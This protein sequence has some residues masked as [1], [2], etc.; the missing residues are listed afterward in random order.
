M[1]T[2]KFVEKL[3]EAIALELA[4]LLQYNQYGQVL[5]GQ[6]RRVWKDFFIDASDEALS[7]VR[8]WGERVV[9]LGG[10]PCVEPDVVM[11]TNDLKQMLENSLEVEKRAVVIY[12]EA[13]ALT[14]RTAY[15][16]MLEDHIET[17]TQ[18]VEELLMYLDK[19]KKV[20]PRSKS[21]KAKQTG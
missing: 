6:D 1:D 8:K 17:E 13:L 21:S 4:A 9:A 14:D 12:E 16:N 15:R 19:V 10:V 3:N 11:Q 7:H 5:M 2:A 20:E 18:D